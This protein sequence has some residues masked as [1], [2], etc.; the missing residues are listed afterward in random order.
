MIL[1]SI[2]LKTQINGR[3]RSNEY[4]CN[5]ISNCLANSVLVPRKKTSLIRIRVLL[6]DVF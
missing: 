6:N 3:R 4:N 1:R 2:N 5:P